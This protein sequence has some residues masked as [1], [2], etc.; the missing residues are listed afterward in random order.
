MKRLCRIDKEK[1][2]DEQHKR[3]QDQPASQQY[4]ETI[5]KMK[6]KKKPQR[7]GW[8]IKAEDGSIITER[9][10][11]IKRW[12]EFYQDLYSDI[13]TSHLIREGIGETSQIPCITITELTRAISQLNAN[14]AQGPDGISCE[15]FKHG[16]DSLHKVLLKLM[17]EIVRGDILPDAFNQSEII[18]IHKKGSRL[19]CGNYRPISLLSHGYKLLMQILYNRISSTLCDI[20]PQT[21]AAYQKG[22][23][24]IEQIQCLQQIIEKTLEFNKEC[25]ICF[26]DF[27][28][29][30]DSIKQDKLWAAL[31]QH[32]DLDEA[33]VTLLINVYAV[34]KTRIRTDAGLTTL[35][36][37]LKRTKQGDLLSAILFCVALAIIF[38]KTFEGITPGVSIGGEVFCDFAYA[39]DAAL[40]TEDEA[41]MCELMTKL[42]DN[43]MEFGLEINFDKTKLMFVGKDRIYQEEYMTLAGQRVDIVSSFE[44]L[45]RIIS[46]NGDDTLAVEA[47]IC[48]AWQAFQNHKHLITSNHLSFSSKRKV[49]ETYVRPV[50]L[51]AMETIV[52]KPPLVQKITVFQNHIMRWITGHRLIDRV[53]ISDL[54][55]QT[56]L[57]PIINIIKKQKM[58]WFGHMKRSVLP[59]RT[60]FEGMVNGTRRRGRPQRRWRTDIEEWSE[61]SWTQ[62]NRAVH[63]RDIWRNICSNFLEF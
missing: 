63:D 19:D 62:I 33:Y 11:V 9:D 1:S 20:L 15:M 59:I 16:G 36:E 55:Q 32:T 35:I 47:R 31:L 52:W 28:K 56:G 51:Y 30:F 24:T 14:K 54:Q 6:N 8:N 26:V 3:I 60:V 53:S 29:A 10:E 58:S 42:N 41:S 46:N 18:L 25:F 21:Q 4:F 27:R 61:M 13:R 38:S 44:Y 57:E 5:K 43:A 48:K 23:S 7:K 17:N 2:I 40:V 37:L 34:S 45:G 12:K 50:V 39:D 49:Y 22:R